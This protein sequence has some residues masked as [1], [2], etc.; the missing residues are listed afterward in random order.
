MN[1]EKF[2][3]V[4]TSVKIFT[5]FA[6]LLSFVVLF[7]KISYSFYV[8]T[9][10]LFLASIYL[11]YRKIYIKRVFINAFAILLVILKFYNVSLE[12]VLQPALEV[13]LFLQ[14]LKF[15]EEK[16]F[17]DYMQIYLISVFILAGSTLIFLNI[18][19]LVYL[20][21]Y[22][23]LLNTS[24]IFLTYYS[25]DKEITLSERVLIRIFLKTSLI[26]LLAIPFTALF[27]IILPRT[28]FPL[29]G[30]LNK[31]AKA[32]TGFSE[33]VR[34][35]EVS[36]IQE[37][38][39]VIFRAKTK[40]L[41]DE[42]LYWRGIALNFFDGKT[43][44][45]TKTKK[46]QEEIILKGLPVVQI[47]YLEPYGDR[48]LFGLDK[49]YDINYQYGFTKPSK[50]ENLTFNLPIPVVS[51]IKYR[52]ISILTEVIPEKNV[53]R[54]LYLQLPQNIS[55]KIK[56]LA[57]SLKGKTDE[58]TADKILKFLRYGDYRYSL[59][60]LPVSQNPLE[61]FLFNYKYGNCEYF[62]SSMAV[63]LR[64]NG[65]P[66]RL[67]AGYRGGIYNE[68]GGYYL[69]RQGDAHVWVEVFI[70]DKGW[71]RYDPTPPS[72]YFFKK[73]SVLSKLELIFETINYYYINFVL[74]YDL[75]KQIA[76]VKGISNLTKIP[77]AKFNKNLLFIFS[78]V[79]ITGF[80]G[81]LLAKNLKGF[82]RLRK[83]EKLIKEF[84][85]IL[86]T[87]GYRKDE[88]EG[89]EEFALKIKEGN[90]RA[91]TLEFVKIFEENYYK[92]KLFTK[93]ELNK[94]REIINKLKGFS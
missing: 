23:L 83:E 82:K 93:K 25:Q 88:N 89:L 4:E 30:F 11:E 13:L 69:V 21:I 68:A 77:R 32:K 91:L 57:F 26:P 51:R 92:D 39:S 56:T 24:I 81:I 90:L 40:K 94:L 66:S 27:F 78:F 71:V 45:S 28:D 35:G 48:Y 34:L 38:N 86:E 87:K 62:A 79:F 63:L 65:I 55:S 60:D 49:P 15:L 74:N 2:Y 43:W 64:L 41:K 7:G 58:E 47:I 5:Y 18:I 20:F 22:I 14:S 84:L 12:I 3:K 1:K 37:D 85:R 72:S 53:D 19:F 42:L 52:V 76:L 17:R 75:K 61:D 73:K 36:E 67:V 29:F 46:I 8:F 50:S 16:K 54:E 59:K 80:I 70:R 10:L 31:E 33:N 6:G 44:I 9:F